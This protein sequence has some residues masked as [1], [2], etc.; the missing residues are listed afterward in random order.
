MNFRGKVK[1]IFNIFVISVLVIYA[2][3]LYL[4]I[5]AFLYTSFYMSYRYKDID[6]DGI[7]NMCDDDVD[8]DGILNIYDDDADGDGTD[9]IQ[10]ALNNARCLIGRPYEQLGGEFR[11]VGFK[12][13]GIVCIDLINLAYEKAG[14]YFEKE[15]RDYYYKKKEIFKNRRW[16]NPDD[17]CFA[18]RVINFEAYCRDRGFMLK[19]DEKLR[20][21]DLISFMGRHI[22]MVEKVMDNDFIV[23]ESSGKRY[24]TRR[25]NKKELYERNI[26]KYGPPTFIR[27]QFKTN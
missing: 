19:N 22:V 12:F 6:R 17:R 13:G 7:I 26:K 16:N 15:L 14:I 1:K 23:I 5:V 3:L 27:L 10:D 9:N 11:D 4:L 21:G 2:N 8:G 20:P 24:F 18:R 25:T